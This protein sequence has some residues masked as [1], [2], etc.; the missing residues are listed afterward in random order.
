MN[1]G[2]GISRLAEEMYDDGFEKII[3]VDICPTAVKFMNDKCRHKKDD[4]KYE[5]MDIKNLTFED[6]KFDV[7]IDK[8]T[9]DCFFVR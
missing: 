6:G 9:L 7:A 2:A 3:S 4:F 1:A 8:A 5:V